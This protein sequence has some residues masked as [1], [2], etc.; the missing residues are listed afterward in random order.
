MSTQWRVVGIALIALALTGCG[1][2]SSRVQSIPV[3]GQAE[4]HQERDVVQ[5]GAFAAEDGR[6]DRQRDASFAACMVARGY[7]VALPVRVGL[8]H[9]LVDL[10]ARDGLPV[11][12][13]ANDLREC[14]REVEARGRTESSGEVV[15]ARIGGLYPSNQ[16]VGHTFKSEALERQFA[17]CFTGRGYVSAPAK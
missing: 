11:T 7:R 5:C 3:R 17:A 1:S 2:V 6:D 15:A 13:A 9:G 4:A 16:D 8:E 14:A 12:Q 10:E